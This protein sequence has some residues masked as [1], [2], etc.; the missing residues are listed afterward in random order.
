MRRS[1]NAACKSKRLLTMVLCRKWVVVVQWQSSVCR[2]V[3]LGIP[4][5]QG[6]DPTWRYICSACK[7]DDSETWHSQNAGFFICIVH[8]TTIVIRKIVRI[9]CHSS[10]F[11]PFQRFP[12]W[13]RKSAKDF[14]EG[15]Q[16]N[17]STKDEKFLMFMESSLGCGPLPGCQ[18]PPGLLHF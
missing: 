9:P 18:W 8:H 10:P 1:G 2:L 5:C 14:S 16:G 6:G 3:F 17:K 4:H 7:R 12:D 13:E 15:G 11:T